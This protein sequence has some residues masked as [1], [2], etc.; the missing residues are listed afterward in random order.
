M[1]LNRI[2]GLLLGAVLSIPASAQLSVYV[3]SA[4]PPMRYEQRG[5][6]P[7]QGYVWIDG[8]WTPNGHHYR[9]VAG[10]WERPPY[11]GAVW[12]HAHYDHYHQGWQLHEGHWEHSDHDR[13]HGHDQDHD[14]GH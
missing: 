14:R 7:G 9:W 1:R 12:S 3:G 2:L 13:D 8:Y 5:P 6:L 10:R 11:E 4:P